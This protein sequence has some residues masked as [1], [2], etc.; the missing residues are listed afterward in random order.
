MENAAFNCELHCTVITAYRGL[1]YYIVYVVGTTCRPLKTRA[2][3]HARYSAL[4]RYYSSGLILG[5]IYRVGIN[6]L[7]YTVS[8]GKMFFLNLALTTVCRG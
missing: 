4:G 5:P 1:V 7:A 3:L 6:R 8:E 2:H